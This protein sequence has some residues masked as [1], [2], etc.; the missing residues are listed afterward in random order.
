MS[1]QDHRHYVAFYDYRSC[2]NLKRL[3]SNYDSAEQTI[4]RLQ[5]S[6]EQLRQ[7]QMDLYK[8]SQKVLTTDFEKVVIINRWED[9][10]SK[11]VNYSIYIDTRPKVDLKNHYGHPIPGEHSHKE[12]FFGTE[13]HKAKKYALQLAKEHKA[14]IEQRGGANLVK[15]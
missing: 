9:Y 5:E 7:Y 1:Y 14:T 4:E 12:N 15:C 3:K 11:K 13:R 10:P 2:Y 6:I 8:H